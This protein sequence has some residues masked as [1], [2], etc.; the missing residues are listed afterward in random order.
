MTHKRHHPSI[1]VIHWL[2]AALIIAALV[3][4]ALVMP[5]IPDDSPEKIAALR[6]HMAAGSL[7]FVLTALRFLTR[8]RV[9][10]PAPLSSGMPW[11]DWLARAVHRIFD[12]LILTMICSGAGMAIVSGVLRIVLGQPGHLPANLDA[13][14]LHMLHR[15]TAMVL[16]AM[17]SLHIGGALYHQVI[18]RDNLISRMGFPFPRKRTQP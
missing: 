9:K 2:V 17:L 18:L 13:L 3:M 14:P 15:Y 10:R 8:R 4:S 5:G 1:R 7:V 16:F 11:A 12:L 6:R